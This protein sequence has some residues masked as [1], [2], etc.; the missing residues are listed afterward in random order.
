ME[1]EGGAHRAQRLETYALGGVHRLGPYLSTQEGPVATV[2]CLPKSW[3][4]GLT[5]APRYPHLRVGL[6][7]WALWVLQKHPVDIILAGQN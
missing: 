1:G 4:T 3:V 5:C 6:S 2:Q 7:S